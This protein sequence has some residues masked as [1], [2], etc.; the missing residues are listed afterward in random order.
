MNYFCLAFVVDILGKTMEQLHNQLS[1][2]FSFKFKTH[3]RFFINFFSM[4]Q[5]YLSGNLNGLAQ[6]ISSFFDELLLRVSQIL[7][8]VTLTDSYTKCV[9][10]GI[11][12]KEPFLRIPSLVINMTME[13][14]PPIRMAINSLA[15]ARETLLAASITVSVKPLYHFA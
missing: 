3:E 1:T 9:I 6:L 14:F 12:S 15:F 8:N 10:D 2:D 11:R 5:S 4:I 7:L 13:T